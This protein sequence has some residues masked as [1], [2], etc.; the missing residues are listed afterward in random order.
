MLKP[1]MHV[2]VWGNN[3]PHTSK[4]HNSEHILN[5]DYS[6][7]TSLPTNFNDRLCYYFD[8]LALIWQAYNNWNY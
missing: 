3:N 2:C 8:Y 1:F 7:Y 5:V 4:T 6:D